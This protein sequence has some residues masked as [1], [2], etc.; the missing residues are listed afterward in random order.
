MLHR[1]SRIDSRFVLI[2]LLAVLAIFVPR[3]ADAQN[4]ARQVGIR[5]VAADNV[6]ATM[7]IYGRNFCLNPVVTL[8]TTVLEV[9]SVEV[10]ADRAD[11]ITVAMPANTPPAGY[12]LTVECGSNNKGAS[13]TDSFDL[14]GGGAVGDVGPQGPRGPAGPDG[15]TGPAGPQGDTGAIGATGPAGADGATGATGSAGADGATGATGPPG[16]AGATGATGAPGPQGGQGFPGPQGAQGVPGLAGVEYSAGA[17]NGPLPSL[18][19]TTYSA[20]CSAGK[21]VIGG[22][23]R[24]WATPGCTGGNSVLGTVSISEPIGTTSWRIGIFNENLF[25]DLYVQVVAVC[26]TTS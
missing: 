22:G 11:A 26:A 3:L 25:N 21:T 24:T 15:A 18:N 9:L 16:V 2:T 8:S 4:G 5:K 19:S 6:A 1:S 13:Q 20:S 10:G 12:R 17:C 23:V 7:T 14:G